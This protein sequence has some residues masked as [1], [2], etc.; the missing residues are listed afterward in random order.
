MVDFR[1][2]FFY[3]RVVR[4]WNQQPREVVE[5]LSLEMFKKHFSAV[6]RDVLQWGNI[7]SRWAAGLDG[8]GG[9]CQ[10]F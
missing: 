8:F 5:S 6:L 9:L 7:G 2:N 1:K 10:H 4:N 3:E